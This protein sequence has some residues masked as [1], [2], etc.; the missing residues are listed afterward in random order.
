MKWMVMW[1]F[2]LSGA[3]PVLMAHG[4][5]PVDSYT[6]Y[7]DTTNQATI[8][9]LLAKGADNLLTRPENQSLNQTAQPYTLWA[10]IDLSKSEDIRDHFLVINNPVLDQASFYLVW[11]DSLCI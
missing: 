6:L 9:G 8:E 7:W 3:T 5:Y 1:L 2:T 4:H 10:E 11:K